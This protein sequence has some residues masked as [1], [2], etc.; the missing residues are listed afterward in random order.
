MHE[1]SSSTPLPG[2][3]LTPIVRGQLG[4]VSKIREEVE[5][6]CDAGRQG[7]RIME[8]VEL[9]DLYGAME[10]FLEKHFPGFSMKDVAD[11]SAVTRR[12]FR[13]GRRVAE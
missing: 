4:E 13:N 12:A 5:E 7:V 11:M 2:Y 6:L 9:S 10:A 3:H 1:P 8:L